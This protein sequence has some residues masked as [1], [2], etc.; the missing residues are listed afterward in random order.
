[1]D[2]INQSKILSGD[3]PN[4]Q[5]NDRFSAFFGAIHENNTKNGTF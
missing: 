4:E 5:R 2:K 1:M 3:A